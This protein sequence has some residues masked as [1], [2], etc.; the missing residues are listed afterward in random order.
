ME[1]LGTMNFQA[2]DKADVF[3]IAEVWANG[4]SM[5]DESL[6][7]I[8]D[9]QFESDHAWVTGKV[10]KF[11]DVHVDGD[12]SLI[13][14]WFK[15]EHFERSFCITVYLEYEEVEQLIEVEPDQEASESQEQQKEVYL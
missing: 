12:N 14:A 2:Q 1:R 5:S 6:L 13:S 10:P 8:E 3:L 11:K 4:L 7:N 15:G 9:A